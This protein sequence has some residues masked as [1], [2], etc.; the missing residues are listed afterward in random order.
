MLGVPFLDLD[1]LVEKRAGLPVRRIFGEFGEEGFRNLESEVL[2]EWSRKEGPFVMALG[3]GTLLRGN[4]LEIVTTLGTLVM[5]TAPDNI[6]ARRNASSP[7]KRPLAEDGG[8]LK[9]LLESRKEHYS[10]LPAPI[11]T[12]SMTPEEA[13][14]TVLALVTGEDG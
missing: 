2:L 13:A 14:G 9:N 6:L 3:G 12:G 11:D 4:N 5:L 7:G 1:E 10:T 8:R